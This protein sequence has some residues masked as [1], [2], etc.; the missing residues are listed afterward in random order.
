MRVVIVG[1][2]MTGLTAAAEVARR[3][4]DAS[5]TV[6][7]A[8]DRVGGKVLTSAFA[9]RP[10]DCGADAFLARVPEGL[11]LCRRLGLDDRLVT[12]AT[13]QAYVYSRGALRPFPERTVLGV[14][15]DLDALA[16]SEVL[17]PAGVERARADLT[18]PGGPLVGDRSV[19]SLVRE[20]LGDEVFER[21]V[22]PLLSGVNAGD[23][24][25]LSLEAGAPQLAAAVREQP[26]LIA[27]L[28]VQSASSGGDSSAPIFYGV[29]SGTQT[30]TDTLA[31]H[32]RRD[33]VDI[34]LRAEVR[35]L[36][37]RSDQAAGYRLRLAT[38]E[39]LDAEAV[40]L[41]VPDFVAARLLEPLAPDVATELGAVEYASVVMVTLAVPRAGI[42]RPLDGSGFLVAQP[43]GLLLTAC[44]WASSKWA[45]LD[46]PD[47]VIL[48]ASAGRHHDRRAL[49]LDDETLIDALVDDLGLTMALDATPLS[50]RVSRWVDALP[51]FR[52]GHLDRVARWRSAMREECPGVVAAGAGIEGLGL[53]ACIRQGWAAAA[54]VAASG[55]R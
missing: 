21:L 8:S 27:G 22:G 13:R 10:V 54:T 50:A 11:E 14:P 24:D 25:K 39:M 43:E 34:I 7:E 6:L 55:E 28:R 47:T 26:S 17:S 42:D 12:P 19:G 36:R 41:A 9:G 31:E 23:A 33:G 20:R 48:R 5:V 16:R 45:H 30:I 49:E 4:P 15:T 2:G 44:S 32:A 37:R 51:Q 1:A 52:P 18:L 38:D 35:G 40:V 53:P 46:Q 29:P 3:R